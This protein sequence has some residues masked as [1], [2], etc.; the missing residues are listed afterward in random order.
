MLLANSFW[1]EAICILRLSAPCSEIR[2][3][4][5]LYKRPANKYGRPYLA[6]CPAI[7]RVSQL[8]V[9]ESVQTQ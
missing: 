5:P 2:Q 1:G 9:R 4:G 3:P 6:E 8:D 7:R